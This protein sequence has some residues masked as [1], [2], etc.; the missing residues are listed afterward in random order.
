MKRGPVCPG[1][2]VPIIIWPIPSSSN[3][4][5]DELDDFEELDDFDELEDDWIK[6]DDVVNYK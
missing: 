4:K 5:L 1:S 2:L 3:D 6:V